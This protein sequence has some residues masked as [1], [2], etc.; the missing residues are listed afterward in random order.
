M[1]CGCFLYTKKNYWYV[2][3]DGNWSEATIRTNGKNI[4]TRTKEEKEIHQRLIE[5]MSDIFESVF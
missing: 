4:S 1:H 5:A 2:H 3:C